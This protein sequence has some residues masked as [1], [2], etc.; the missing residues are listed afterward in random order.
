MIVGT[1]EEKGYDKVVEKGVKRLTYM[2]DTSEEL[3]K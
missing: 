3:E 1:E 2:K